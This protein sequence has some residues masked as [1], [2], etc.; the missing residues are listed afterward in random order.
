MLI[1]L[2]KN[3][4]FIQIDLIPVGEGHKELEL[5]S[6][7]L[8]NSHKPRGYLFSCVKFGHSGSVEGTDEVEDAHA[9][10]HLPYSLETKTLTEPGFS[11]LS[12]A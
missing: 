4:S 1:L 9:L 8:N 2:E 5:Y 12:C 10:H 11:S 3:K 7:L 6:K